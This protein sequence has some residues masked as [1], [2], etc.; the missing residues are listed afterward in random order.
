MLISFKLRGFI[1]WRLALRPQA[2]PLFLAAP[3]RG[4]AISVTEVQAE[5]GSSRSIR[6]ERKFE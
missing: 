6:F 4:K 2:H 1:V 5:M 3:S